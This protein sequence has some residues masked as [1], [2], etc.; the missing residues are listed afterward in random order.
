MGVGYAF[1]QPVEAESP[2]A[3]GH[4]YAPNQEG[5]AVLFD[6]PEGYW[7][8]PPPLPNAAASLAST[9]DDFWAFVQLLC[10]GGVVGD[11]RLLSDESVAAMTRDHVDTT[12]RHDAELFL[13]GS[14]WGYCMAA[15]P[16][17]GAHERV[18]GYG[19]EGGSGTVWRTQPSTGL[20]GIL[21][22]Q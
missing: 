20:T 9:L 22:T 2:Q 17:D 19:W 15:P 18:P 12:Q 5:E 11:Q 21:F 4:A 6:R 8:V 1:D 16:A 7:A 14:R 13:S 10:N 3:I